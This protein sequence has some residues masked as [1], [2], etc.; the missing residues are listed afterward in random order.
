MGSTCSPSHLRGW[1]KK[2]G[3]CNQA[4]HVIALTFLGTHLPCSCHCQTLWAAPRCLITVPPQ[5]PTT[6]SSWCRP[7]AWANRDRVF[8]AWSTGGRGKTLQLSLTLEVGMAH[9]HWG[10]LKNHS[11][12]QPPQRAPQ[13]RTLQQNTICCCPHSPGST[14][15]QQ[16]PLPNALCSAQTLDHCPFPGTYD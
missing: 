15:T 10:S 9:C 4:P 5:D 7:P 6:R 1:Q 2:R 11:H 13:K 8:L 16:L 12:P 3:H 14:P